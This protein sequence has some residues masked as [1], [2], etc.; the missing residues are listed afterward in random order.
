MNK[1]KTLKKRWKILFKCP[2]WRSFILLIIAEFFI[3]ELITMI[4][5]TKWRN[6]KFH[7]QL[8]CMY[9]AIYIFI[10]KRDLS[11]AMSYYRYLKKYYM[12]S[13]V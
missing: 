10:H 2:S 4:N 3:S 8:Q 12:I 13:Y 1:M 5:K 11:Y 9:L 7:G 6:D